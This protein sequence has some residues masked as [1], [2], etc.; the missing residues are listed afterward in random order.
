MSGARIADI[1]NL[2]AAKSYPSNLL[3]QIFLRHLNQ[4]YNYEGD[5]LNPLKIAIF[6]G[7]IED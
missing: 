1:Y 6:R 4:P 2:M 3:C 7:D 5:I